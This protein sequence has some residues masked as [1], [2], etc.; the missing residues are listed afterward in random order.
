M[1]FTE[2][3]YLKRELQKLQ[4]ENNQLSNLVEYYQEF[5]QGGGRGTRPIDPTQMG[6]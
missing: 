6:M 1:S 2:N 3:L 5:Q 4:E